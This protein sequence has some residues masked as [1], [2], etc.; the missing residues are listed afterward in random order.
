M[1]W[2]LNWLRGFWVFCGVRR[3]RELL[4]S[5][6]SPC[7]ASPF[8]QSPQKEPKSLAP[9]SGPALRYGFVL[10]AAAP[11][12]AVQGP[13]MA[14]YGGTPS[15]LSA[16]MPLAPL[17]DG[18]VHPPEGAIGSRLGGSASRAMSCP[19]LPR[20]RGTLM[21]STF[22]HRSRA[23]ALCVTYVKY[24]YELSTQKGVALHVLAQTTR[25]YRMPLL[26]GRMESLR[27]GERHGCCE[28]TRRPRD[29]GP[30][31]ALVRRPPERRWSEGSRAQR[32]GDAQFGCR[33][34]SVFGYF[35]SA[36]QA[37]LEKVTRPAGR[38]RNCRP[39]RKTALAC[40]PP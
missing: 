15:S 11:R 5:W 28:R 1:G 24:F 10:S 9:A 32:T 30:W 3:I 17:H 36:G 34:R 21:V 16:S 23:L 35:F 14:L 37:R 2:G 40:S 8:W 27:R 22:Q 29:K 19:R 26:G 39:L 38:N 33:G 4:D 18:S 6:V 20:V 31:M 7:W 25:Q 13:S 12:V